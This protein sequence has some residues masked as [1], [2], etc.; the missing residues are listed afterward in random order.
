MNNLDPGFFGEP[1]QDARDAFWSMEAARNDFIE[2]WRRWHDFRPSEA[3]VKDATARV[4][5]QIGLV[6]DDPVGG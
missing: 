5:A 6:S 2:A 1:D 4:V 3:A